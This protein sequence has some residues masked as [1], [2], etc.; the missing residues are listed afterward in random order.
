MQKKIGKEQHA[1]AAADFR[2]A[3][4][5]NSLKTGHLPAYRRY[6][7]AKLQYGSRRAAMSGLAFVGK[8]GQGYL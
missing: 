5:R 2:V 6:G 1:S 7:P 3:G 4:D 8:T